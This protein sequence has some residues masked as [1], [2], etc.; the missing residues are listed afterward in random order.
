MVVYSSFTALNGLLSVVVVV[1]FFS[2]INKTIPYGLFA[3]WALCS[4]AGLGEFWILPRSVQLLTA[5][6]K[7]LT[8]S[9]LGVWATS[10]SLVFQSVLRQDKWAPKGKL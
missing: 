7:L 10:R 4:T 3:A 9:P 1:F 5:D 6:V 2:K 8:S